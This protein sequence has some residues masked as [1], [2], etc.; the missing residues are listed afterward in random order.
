MLRRIL[1]EEQGISNKVSLF[2]L[3]LKNKISTDFGKNK[4]NESL[5]KILPLVP[6][7]TITVINNSFDDLFENEIITIEYNVG[8][9]KTN[10]EMVLYKKK[11]Q[12]E[13]KMAGKKI[14]LYLTLN[15]NNKINWKLHLSSLQHE[16]HHLF[17]TIKKDKPLIDVADMGDY[18]FYQNLLKSEDE[19][20]KII[21]YTLYYAIKAEK[22]AFSNGLYREIMEQNKET[23]N[24]SPIKILQSNITY[25]NI[26]YID[27]YI[28]N[29]KKINSLK[30]KLLEL[31]IDFNSYI[32]I[33]FNVVEN[34]IKSF[35]RIVYKAKQDLSKLYNDTLK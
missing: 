9:P 19:S 25:K 12:S 32:N 20:E 13:M 16:V 14:I 6:N 5:Y 1:K 26:K 10:Q 3:K 18:N 24:T 8:L 23:Y 17:Q 35:S 29:K 30:F 4:Y 27:F 15:E 31:N 28:N 33:A 21:G 11:Y 2:V 7:K 22:E 34:Y